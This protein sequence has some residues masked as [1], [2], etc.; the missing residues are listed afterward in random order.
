[1]GTDR[2]LPWTPLR[3]LLGFDP[4]Q[5]IRASYGFEYE[6]SRTENGY[7]VEVP[8]PGYNSSQ[9]DVTFKDGILSVSGKTD[10]RSFSRSFTVPE[11]IDADS[12]GARVQDGMLSLSLKRH[13][14]AQ[15]KKIAV[16]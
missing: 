4:F 1:M 9:I 5:N 11:D 13:P 16:G 2:T 6:V 3:D 8:V 7:A 12:I 10:R 15:P 14:E